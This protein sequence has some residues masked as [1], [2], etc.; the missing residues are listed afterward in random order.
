M[1]SQLYQTE[2]ITEKAEIIALQTFKKKKH[3]NKTFD[4]YWISIMFKLLCNWIHCQ[5]TWILMV[6]LQAEKMETLIYQVGAISWSGK[7]H[8]GR[9][10]GG[11]SWHLNAAL[12]WRNL[13]NQ[14]VRRLPPFSQSNKK[15]RKHYY[16]IHGSHWKSGQW[17]RKQ[18]EDGTIPLL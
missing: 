5:H 18:R 4:W 6:S 15:G 1:D 11:H 14:S 16:C 8:R 9:T 2:R 10:N 13:I 17:E 7:A 12:Y 3:P